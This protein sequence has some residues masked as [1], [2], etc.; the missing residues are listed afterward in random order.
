MVSLILCT[1]CTKPLSSIISGVK[2]SI[3]YAEDI[4]L[5]LFLPLCVSESL[6]LSLYLS[7]CLD[8][9]LSVS[10]SLGHY[11]YL[12]YLACLIQVAESQLKAVGVLV[13]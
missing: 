3:I 13:V 7:V 2:Y 5:S 11:L 6:C 8:L 12:S 1:L 9:F 10:L 4:H